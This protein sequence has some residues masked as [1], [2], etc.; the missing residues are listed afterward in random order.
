MSPQIII[1]PDKQIEKLIE[2]KRV[3]AEELSKI[4][5]LSQKQIRRLVS[6][7]INGAEVFEQRFE[8]ALHYHFMRAI[9]KPLVQPRI[10]RFARCADPQKPYFWFQ[11]PDTDW[12]KITIVPISDV[13]YGAAECDVKRL[14]E[15]VSWIV[16]NDNVF[17]FLN[18]DIVNN[19]LPDSPGGSIFWDTIRP[20]NQ[21]RDIIEI[22]A[23]IAHKILFALPGNHEGRTIQRADIDPLFWVCDKPGIPYS[24]QP[25]FVDILWQ[26]YR[27]NM[28]CFHGVSGSRTSGGKL[29]AAMR[30]IDWTEFTMFYVMGHVHDPM[31][32]P[33]VRRCIVRDYD[34][35]GKLKRLR[36]VDRDQ[37]VI[38]CAAWLE[39]WGGYGAKMGFSPPSQGATPCYLRKDGSYGTSE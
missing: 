28:Y 20:R 13:Q 29:N 4:C 25:V 7:G 31:G 24:D 26:G 15:Y 8:K 23:P 12:K 3:T 27:F 37:Y 22:L 2:K 14:K 1:I 6:D 9:G 35:R 5:G 32:N 11:F 18:G 16:R 36:V 33:V 38:I 21:V 30:P 39:F 10:W 34:D 19:A 17:A